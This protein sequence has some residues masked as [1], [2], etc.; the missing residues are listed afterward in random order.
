MADDLFSKKGYAGVTLREIAD[1]VGMRQ[2]SLYYYV[3]KGKEQLFIE[4]MKRTYARHR[5][6]LERAIGEAG[7][8]LTQRLQAIAAWLLSQP[9]VDYIRVIFSDVSTLDPQQAE[10]LVYYANSSLVE[11]IQTIIEDAKRAGIVTSLDAEVAANGLIMML[12]GLHNVP[13]TYTKHSRLQLADM[14]IDMVLNGW[15]KR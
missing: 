12:E 11:P 2:A 15:V 9:P 14:L 4:V 3:P 5:E 13:S 6:G 10:W 7:S 1:E 8:D